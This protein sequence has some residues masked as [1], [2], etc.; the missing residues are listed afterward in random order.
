MPKVHTFADTSVHGENQSISFGVLCMHAEVVDTDLAREIYMCTGLC[1][2]V[3][4]GFISELADHTVRSIL[5]VPKLYL[6]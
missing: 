3:S 6:K 5:G 4:A 1:P 2:G